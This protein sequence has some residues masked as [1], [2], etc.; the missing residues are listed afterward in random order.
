[1]IHSPASER[2]RLRL[3]SMFKAY[4]G[5]DLGRFEAGDVGKRC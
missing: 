1:M 2:M 3:R 5:V 4:Q